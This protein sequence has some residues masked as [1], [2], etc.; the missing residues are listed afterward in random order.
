MWQSGQLQLH[1]QNIQINHL[2]NEITHKQFLDNPTG[3]TIKH[4]REFVIHGVLS[5]E[6]SC[7]PVVWTL[8]TIPAPAIVKEYSWVNTQQSL[9]PLLKRYLARWATL[10]VIR[11]VHSIVCSQD[12]IFSEFGPEVGLRP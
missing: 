4:E 2:N 3:R 9:F 12:E 10:V 5:W 11:E 6:K 8:I 7:E 1:F